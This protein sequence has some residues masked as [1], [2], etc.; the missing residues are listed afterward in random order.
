MHWWLIVFLSSIDPQTMTLWA[1][2]YNLGRNIR[3]TFKIL[4]IYASKDADWYYL[5][6]WL[7]ILYCFLNNLYFI[8]TEIL[9]RINQGAHVYSNLSQQ[10]FHLDSRCF[11]DN[12]DA[13]LTHGKWLLFLG[14]SNI[15]LDLLNPPQMSDHVSIHYYLAWCIIAPTLVVWNAWGPRFWPNTSWCCINTTPQK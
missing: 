13:C 15:E 12:L 2:A 9:Y 5:E 14:S 4:S 6:D 1:L 11:P 3:N 7:E 10:Y 8:S